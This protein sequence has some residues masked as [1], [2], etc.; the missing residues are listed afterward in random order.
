MS[1]GNVRRV[2]LDESFQKGR[3]SMANTLQYGGGQGM[4]QSKHIPQVRASNAITIGGNTGS[5]N[6]APLTSSLRPNMMLS[7][8]SRQARDLLLKPGL[9][10]RAQTQN[11][12][13]NQQQKYSQMFKKQPNVEKIKQA[14]MNF[15]QPGSI[16]NFNINSLN[17]PINN[18]N[19]NSGTG[20]NSQFRS[21][22]V[23]PQNNFRNAQSAEYIAELE[24]QLGELRLEHN[25]M[26][27]TIVAYERQIEQFEKENKYVQGENANLLQELSTIAQVKVKLEETMLELERMKTD[28]DFHNE[29]HITL[30]NDMLG[31]VKQEYELESIKREKNFISE[32]L[33]AYKEKTL[34]YEKQID[35]LTILAKRPV[36]INANKGKDGGNIQEHYY[37]KVKKIF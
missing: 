16:Q 9:E 12:I 26:R 31:I 5:P 27:R 23:P 4:V 37:A 34:I 10:A 13:M 14:D 24:K 33:Q 28:R 17:T 32:E 35:E 15:Q 1:S 2:Q 20:A 29:Q 7:T 30:R 19:S 21:T 3:S 25:H 11:L 6:R 8:A 18:Y 36:S 22:Y